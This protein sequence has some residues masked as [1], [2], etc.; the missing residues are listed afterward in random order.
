MEPVKPQQEHEW[1]GQLIGDWESEMECVMGPD[2]PP[3]KSKG[4]ESVRSLGG[5][6]TIGE[7]KGEQPDGAGMTSILTLGYDPAQKCF[8]GTFIASCMTFLWIYKN[9]SL[10]AAKKILTMN[11]EGPSFTGEGM[12]Q[13]QD[14]LEIVDADHRILRS[15]ILGADGKWNHFMTAHYYRKK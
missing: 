4:T 15:Q 2:Q 9:G 8:V 11:A 10:D 6:W 5:L 1:L 7:G 14:I 3:M 13:Y 12:S